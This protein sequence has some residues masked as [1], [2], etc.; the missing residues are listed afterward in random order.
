MNKLK[1]DLIIICYF[2]CLVIV[3]VINFKKNLQNKN[4][5]NHLDKK[6]KN[7]YK[8]FQISTDL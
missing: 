5:I 2:K 4:P 3:E 1:S 6:K 8:I 7:V